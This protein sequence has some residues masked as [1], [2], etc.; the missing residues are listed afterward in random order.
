MN[1]NAALGRS[2]GSSA[3]SRGEDRGVSMDRQPSSSGATHR[4][5]PYAM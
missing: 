3:R 1:L 4:L 2:A 5:V